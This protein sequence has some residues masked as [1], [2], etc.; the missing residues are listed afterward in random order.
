MLEVLTY[1]RTEVEQKKAVCLR[2][3]TET[4]A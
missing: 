1:Q 3:E 2:E 4:I